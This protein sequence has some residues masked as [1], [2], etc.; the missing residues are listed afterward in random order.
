MLSSAENSA[1]YIY[2][3]VTATLYTSSVATY[4]EGE[5]LKGDSRKIIA[6]GNGWFEI[7]ILY[8]ILNLGPL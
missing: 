2:L 5:S 4:Y 6:F 7:C 1:V 3:I 8:L